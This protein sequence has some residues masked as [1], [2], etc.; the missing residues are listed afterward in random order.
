MGASHDVAKLNN[1]CDVDLQPSAR[2]A[3]AGLVDLA[4]LLLG[5]GLDH[6]EQLGVQP[7]ENSS[8]RSGAISIGTPSGMIAGFNSVP[9]FDGEGSTRIALLSMSDT[10]CC[11]LRPTASVWMSGCL[12]SL[13]GDRR[14]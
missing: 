2:S 3:I 7:G 14:C 4:Q 11:R 1:A 5:G 8:R 6:L 13:L 10:T 12:A 9:S